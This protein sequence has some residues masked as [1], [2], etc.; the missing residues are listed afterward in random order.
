[1]KKKGLVFILLIFLLS[2][3]AP[4]CEAASPPKRYISL[5]PSTTE[6]LFALGLKEEIVGVSSYCDF[7]PEAKDKPRVGAFS[8]PNI[9]A[10]ISLRPDYIF[11]TG[12]EQAPVAE[13]LKKMHL[14]VYI[15]DPSSIRELLDSIRIIGRITDKGKMAD[16]LAKKMQ[17]EIDEIRSKVALIPLN[18]R[19]KVFIEIWNNPIITVG[20]GSFVD[21]L[22]NTAG[23]MNIAYDAKRAY[24]IFSPE[25]II[26]RNPDL[27]ILAY[28][29]KGEPL[30]S[31][32]R[33]LGW[34]EVSAVRNKRIYADINPDL[35]LRPGPRVAEGIKQLYNKFFDE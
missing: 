9:E 32:T 33:H 19:P 14:N 31:L 29:E 23:G 28:M 4:A 24:T 25:A 2:C 26:K 6:I 30:K 10:I 34:N 13:Q 11:C 17:K 8:Q 22:V 15:A 21:E 27:I 35:L 20:K 7:P 18:K 1:M 3:N 12:L 16:E 5:A